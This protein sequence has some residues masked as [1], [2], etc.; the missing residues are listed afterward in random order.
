[1][2]P[3]VA[4]PGDTNPSDATVKNAYC[5]ESEEDRERES[6]PEQHDGH[7]I[8]YHLCKLVRQIKQLIT[9]HQTVLLLFILIRYF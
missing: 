4:A 9:D 1:M 3:S 5:K 7:S 2:T 8:I 6:V